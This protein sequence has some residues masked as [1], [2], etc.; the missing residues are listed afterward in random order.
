LPRGGDAGQ[1]VGGDADPDPPVDDVFGDLTIRGRGDVGW[2][3]A[4]AEPGDRGG[5]VPQDGGILRRRTGDSAP[6]MNA[7]K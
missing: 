6:R 5:P 1:R 3:G 2:Y 4:A 7:F